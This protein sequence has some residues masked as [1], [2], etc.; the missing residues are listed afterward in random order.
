AAVKAG[1]EKI[2]AAPGVATNY[3]ELGDIYLFEM[4]WLA[5][6]VRLYEKAT[7]L[8]PNTLGYHWRLMD[9]YL[10]TSRADKMLAELKYLAKHSLGDKQTWDWYQAYKEAYDFGDSQSNMQYLISR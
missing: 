6:A 10:N 5:P 1:E 4:N 8:S 3:A 7:A 9:L 2:R